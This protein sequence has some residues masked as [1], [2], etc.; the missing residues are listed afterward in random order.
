DSK[1][2]PFAL[3]SLINF[4]PRTLSAENNQE[5]HQT[6]KKISALIEKS[7][8]FS[9]IVEQLQQSLNFDIVRLHVHRAESNMWSIP[10]TAGEL[11]RPNYDLSRWPKSGN[12]LV[13]PINNAVINNPNGEDFFDQIPPDSILNGSFAEREQIKSMGY[14][15]LKSNNN[16]IQEGGPSEVLGILFVGHRTPIPW[17]EGLKFTVRLFA[18]HAAAAIQNRRRLRRL[19]EDGIR[20]QTVKRTLEQLLQQ[21]TSRT[22]AWSTLLAEALSITQAEFGFI[23]QCNGYELTIKAVISTQG[24]AYEQQ[25]I[26]Q[27][28]QV[29][30][31]ANSMVGKAID[32][33]KRRYQQVAEPSD[34][35]LLGSQ[36][37]MMTPRT[38]MVAILRNESYD[39]MG[40][41]FVRHSNNNQEHDDKLR[42][43]NLISLTEVASLVPYL[44]RNNHKQNNAVLVNAWVSL[45][46]S[47][48]WKDVLDNIWALQLRLDMAKSSLDPDLFN[49]ATAEYKAVYMVQKQIEESFRI[50]QALDKTDP[51]QLFP[52]ISQQPIDIFALHEN[53]RRIIQE[54]IQ[55]K[56]VTCEPLMPSSQE[57]EINQSLE[58]F[59]SAIRILLEN[60]IKAM[61][62]SEEKKLTVTTQ[63]KRN[64]VWI[65]ITDTGKGLDAKARVR[66][67]Q[68]P[69]DKDPEN[70]SGTGVLMARHIF[71]LLRGDA[72]LI[73]SSVGEGTTVRVKLPIQSDSRKYYQ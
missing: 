34:L 27:Y 58:L 29:V 41:L 52:T 18:N 47:A 62:D 30:I 6:R 3:L 9:R 17:T 66:F 23:A 36:D 26:K 21:H 49:A 51:L 48:W 39:S 10:D 28:D 73:R 44:Y 2:R 65:D 14:V 32:A 64:Q 11:Y 67:F 56:D 55:D 68:I 16:E 42:L 54:A 20:A 33:G 12:D 13:G 4:E 8:I 19:K 46:R 15:V 71:R 43:K 59:E 50:I 5:I 69:F 63:K 45:I 53:L 7:Y 22:D 25:W 31:D 35:F 70:G 37:E 38:A 40:V 57:I 60:A 72:L 1:Q 61:Q 24:A